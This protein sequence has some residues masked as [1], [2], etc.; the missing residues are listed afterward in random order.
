MLGQELI[1]DQSLSGAERFYIRI[2]G[3]P[4]N[5]LRIRARR[6]LPLITA[7]YSKILDAGCGQ[8]I[9][10]FE[11]ARRLPKSQITGIDI[12]KK[13]LERNEKIAKKV[14]LVNCQFLYQDINHLSFKNQYDLVLNV[15][16][17]EHLEEDEKALCNFYAA[18][19]PGGELILH[20]PAYYR[21]WIFFGWKV[22]F[23]VDGHY[24]PGYT[25]EDILEKI[26]RVGFQVVENYYTYGWLETITNNIS[27]LI[28]KARM[29]NKCLYAAVFP[30]LL[31]VS[32]FGRNSKPARGAGVLVIARK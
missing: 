5:G 15:D 9:F 19:K 20:V 2:F 10:T 31:I 7:K 24:R 13:L 1:Y 3:I 28:T 29:K 30:F 14:S 6:I 32:Y 4:I 22:N 23:D 11:M 8:G 26:K 16:N 12:D 21:R 18:L 17:L 25:M 27:Y